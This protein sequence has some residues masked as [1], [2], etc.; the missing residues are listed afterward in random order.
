M[1]SWRERMSVN[2]F[3]FSCF[4]LVFILGVESFFE[5]DEKVHMGRDFTIVASEPGWVQFYTNPLDKTKGMRK[6]VG[7]ALKGNHKL[8]SNPALPRWRRLGLRE[9]DP[10]ED[11]KEKK[12]YY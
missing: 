1:A 7:V 6:Y 12:V 11:I 2:I 4:H 9:V 8:P 5:A 10:T 3:P